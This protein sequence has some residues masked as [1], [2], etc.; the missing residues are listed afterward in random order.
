MDRVSAG[1]VAFI[2]RDLDPPTVET[3]FNE[4]SF[5]NYRL[6]RNAFLLNSY[7]ETVCIKDVRVLIINVT[8]DIDF[9]YERNVPLNEKEVDKVRK[10]VV[11]YCELCNRSSFSDSDIQS[12]M[13]HAFQVHDFNQSTKSFIQA[14]I[15]FSVQRVFSETGRRVQILN[16]SDEKI[17]DLLKDFGN[18]IVTFK[19]H[20]TRKR[21]LTEDEKFSVCFGFVS[22]MRHVISP[23]NMKGILRHAEE[24]RSH[25]YFEAAL[26][27]NGYAFDGGGSGS[28]DSQGKRRRLQMMMRDLRW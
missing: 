11:E 19:E 13:K 21:D 14:I 18:F 6:L 17:A 8:G 2:K 20:T 28:G 5:K 1:Y 12:A 24:L 25:P 9:L 15:S 7:R 16:Y 22:F 26:R 4:L 23:E 27:A 10:T 3:T